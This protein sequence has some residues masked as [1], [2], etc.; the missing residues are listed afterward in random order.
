M[1]AVPDVLA[2]PLEEAARRLSESGLQYEVKVLL[3]PRDS[4]VAF[5]GRSVRKYVVRQQ[6]LSDDK[7]ALTIVYRV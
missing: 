7:Y 5:V 6:R 2:L 1:A 3:P 4:E